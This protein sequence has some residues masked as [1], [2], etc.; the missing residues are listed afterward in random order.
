MATPGIEISD[1]N[2]RE[3]GTPDYERNE[4]TRL[5]GTGSFCSVTNAVDRGFE[6]PT[7]RRR[8]SRS[9]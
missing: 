1:Y 5:H 6:A 7:L 2:F 4:H 8:E 9:T 3:F